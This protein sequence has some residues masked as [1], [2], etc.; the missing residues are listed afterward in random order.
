MK[1]ASIVCGLSIFRQCNMEIF[2]VLP[3]YRVRI[4]CRTQDNWGKRTR[5]NAAFRALHLAQFFLL[6]KFK[7]VLTGFVF[8]AQFFI[9]ILI[10]CCFPIQC[11]GYTTKRAFTC[12]SK[13]TRCIFFRI[14]TIFYQIREFLIFG[15]ASGTNQASIKM[16]FHTWRYIYK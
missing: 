2:A 13:I 6:G 3:A 5:M 7:F 8:I 12:T 11:N 15:F 1:Y 10:F 14:A 4:V 9:F 16:H